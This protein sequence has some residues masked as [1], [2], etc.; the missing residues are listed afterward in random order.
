MVLMIGVIQAVAVR[1]AVLN[2]EMRSQL[3]LLIITL[4]F[5][6]WWNPPLRISFIPVRLSGWLLAEVRKIK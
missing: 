4:G 3:H 6:F 2:R 5:G 1:I